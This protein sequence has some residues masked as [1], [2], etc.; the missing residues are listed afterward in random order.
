MA[1]RF[2]NVFRLGVKELYSLSVDP[3]LLVMIVYAL[4]FAVYAQA[5]GAKFEVEHVGVGF[6]DEDH[7]ELSRRIEA[8]LQEP[9]FKPPVEISADEIDPAMNSGRFVFVVDV[10]PKFEYDALA[11]RQPTVDVDVDATALAQAGIG[12]GD[13]QNIIEQETLNYLQHS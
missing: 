9:L 13:I 12:V 8:A 2:A 4:S 10:P 11:G 7:S 3:I 1:L 5:T 6:V